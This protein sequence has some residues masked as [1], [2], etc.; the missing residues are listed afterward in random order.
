MGVVIKKNKLIIV[1]IM[2]NMCVDIGNLFE[3]DWLIIEKNCIFFLWKS[4]LVIK[5]I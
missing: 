1:N 5:Y 4:I 2:R 3:L